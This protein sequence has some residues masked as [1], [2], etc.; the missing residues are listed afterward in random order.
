[1]KITDTVIFTA[2]LP[3]SVF[4]EVSLSDTKL[5]GGVYFNKSCKGIYYGLP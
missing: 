5:M 2:D 1:M 3:A 4:V